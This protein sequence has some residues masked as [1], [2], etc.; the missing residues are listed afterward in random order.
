MYLCSYLWCMSVP[1]MRAALTLAKSA[2][3]GLLADT[4]GHLFPYS[5]GLGRV[6]LDR[7]IREALAEQER[8]RSAH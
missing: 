8:N 3:R 5:E 6:A 4:Y 7:A 1:G 2:I